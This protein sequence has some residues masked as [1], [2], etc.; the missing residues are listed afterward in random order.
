METKSIQNT[1][2]LNFNQKSVKIGQGGF[3][4]RPEQR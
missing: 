3:L 1:Q 2:Q 4:E